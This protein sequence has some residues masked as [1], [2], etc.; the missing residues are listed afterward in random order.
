MQPPEQQ[1]RIPT[2]C[3]S[4]SR[5]PFLPSDSSLRDEK[6]AEYFQKTLSKKFAVKPRFVA[7]W[8]N[9]AQNIVNFFHD[10]EH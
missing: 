8:V 6:S 10:F 7:I 3:E 5:M 4:C 1:G 2:E 9:F